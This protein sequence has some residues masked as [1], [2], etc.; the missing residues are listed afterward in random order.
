MIN[1]GI[2]LQLLSWSEHI[3]KQGVRVLKWTLVLRAYEKIKALV[4]CLKVISDIGI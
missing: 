1:T 3:V 4:Q 2:S